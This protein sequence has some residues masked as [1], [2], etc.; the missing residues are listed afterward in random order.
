MIDPTEIR[1]R[2]F[3]PADQAD[4][5]AVILTG[6]G[7][8]F[9]FIDETLNPDLDDIAVSYRSGA[10]LVAECEG[11]IVG[12][13]A[14][15]H[16]TDGVWRLH[17]MST[18]KRHRRHRIGARLLARLVERGHDLGCTRIVLDT[19][20]DWHDAIAFYEASDF[21]IVSYARGGVQFERDISR[22]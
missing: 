11:R 12:T 3:V 20:A 9:G 10:F 15:T 18:A 5:R 17:R 22:H 14:L 4:A 7:E 21:T 8:R 2:P 13:G 6:L 19:N 1:I 16:E